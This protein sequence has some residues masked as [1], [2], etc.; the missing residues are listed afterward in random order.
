MLSYSPEPNFFGNDTFHYGITDDDLADTTYVVIDVIP[1]NDAPAPF[2]LLE[3]DSDTTVLVISTL[4][5]HDS[6]VFSWE[7][8]WDVE[9]DPIHYLLEDI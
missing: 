5:D 1:V 6:L 9:G 8:S 2:L 3:P 4:D 7:P